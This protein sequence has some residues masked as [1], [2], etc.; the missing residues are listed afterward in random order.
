MRSSASFSK[1]LDASLRRQLFASLHA[2]TSLN[3]LGNVSWTAGTDVDQQISVLE[4]AFLFPKEITRRET[5]AIVW[6]GIINARKGGRIDDS[7]VMRAIQILLN[8]SL[9]KPVGTYSMWSRLSFRPSIDMSNLNFRYDGISLKIT[10]SLPKYMAVSERDFADL[11]PIKTKDTP[12]FAFVVANAAARNAM[13][14]ADNV[15]NA[16]STMQAI[17]N[18]A[19]R[20]WNLSGSEQ[21]PEALLLLGPYQ[22]M[23]R[24]QSRVRDDGS[25]YN[26]TFRD[27]FWESPI[28]AA[29][30]IIKSAP[31]VRKAL[32]KLET[33]PLREPLSAALQMMND[34]ME[35]A[36]MTLRTLRYW[37]AL[38]R[39]FQ[40][41]EERVPYEKIIRRATYLDDPAELARAKLNR[42]LKIRNRYVHLGKREDHHHQLV[43]YLAAEVRSHLFYILFNGDDFLDHREFIEMTDLPS[44]SDS[45]LRRRRAIE[46]RERMIE[47]R[48]HRED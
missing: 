16:T 5:S 34:G 1:T 25:W 12:S 18:L 36:D 17:Y 37:T 4:D 3:E 47:R 40:S 20:S 41:E 45:L 26:P 46:R 7:S 14:G 8:E 2:A 11:W 13:Q 43:Q 33:H 28:G 19:L 42:L 44:N 38:E 22:F 31:M 30:K 15:F 23:F 48:R 10:R 24:R 27:E 32:S 35:S 29:G 9:S 21:K 39:L 6:K